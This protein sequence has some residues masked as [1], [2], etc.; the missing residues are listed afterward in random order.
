MQVLLIVFAVAFVLSFIP[1]TFLAIRGYRKFR[2]TRVVTC[3]ET[4]APVAVELDAGHAAATNLTGEADLRLKSCTRWPERQDCGQECLAQI[5]AAPEGCLVRTM[6]T[7]WYQGEHCVLCGR[8]FGQ[9]LWSDRKPVLMSPQRVR[10][11]WDEVAPETL[12][13]VL[14]THDRVCWNC[15]MAESFRTL[16]PDLVLDDPLHKEARRSSSR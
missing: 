6:L 11:E 9:I 7:D 3:P 8:E 4:R 1:L 14:A 16:H 2:G 10:M 5:E 13:Q 12:P 15:H